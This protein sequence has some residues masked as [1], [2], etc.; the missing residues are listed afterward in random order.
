M[1]HN[2]DDIELMDENERDS[3]YFISN[4][5]NTHMLN[6]ELAI[7]ASGLTGCRRAPAIIPETEELLPDCFGLYIP[8]S[9]KDAQKTQIDRFYKAYY[10]VCCELKELYADKGIDVHFMHT[11][12]LYIGMSDEEARKWIEL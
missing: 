5:R 3:M 1:D 9:Y 4:F 2:L 8:N 7:K 10:M 12:E 11:M 6:V